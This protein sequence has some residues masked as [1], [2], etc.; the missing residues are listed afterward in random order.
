VETEKEV[1]LEQYFHSN[2]QLH[3]TTK[4]CDYGKAKGAKEYAEETVRS[5]KENL[6]IFLIHIVCLAP[7][8]SHL[9]IS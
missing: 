7:E 2:W 1:D 9:I 5:Q 4:Y 3:C 6:L 8:I